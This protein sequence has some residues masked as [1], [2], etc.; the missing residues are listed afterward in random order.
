MKLEETNFRVD[1]HGWE[2][3]EIDGVRVKISPLRDII[4]T[5]EG[6]GAGE[7]HF[8]WEA[9]VRETA[10]AGKRMPTDPEWDAL[11]AENHPP[12]LPYET[13]KLGLAGAWVEL[14]PEWPEKN[15]K[16]T[17]GDVGQ[18]G[19]Y[20]SATETQ[21]PSD[22][23]RRGFAEGR[24]SVTRYASTKNAYLSVRCVNETPGLKWRIPYRECEIV[25]PE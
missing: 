25:L 8:R 7:Q 2:A 1:S 19:V 17:I 18:M 20:W 10:K 23:W 24:T 4:E 6:E 14:P 22:A 9:A 12:H 3:V 5:L 13:L 11:V 21:V 15:P 16:L